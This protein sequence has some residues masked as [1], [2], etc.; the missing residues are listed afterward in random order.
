MISMAKFVFR[1]NRS[2]RLLAGALALALSF[3]WVLPLQ[4][5]DALEVVKK[6]DAHYYYP[7]RQGVK[8]LSVLIDW[9]QMD[10]ASLDQRY[11]TNP[12]ARFVW[13]RG[14]AGKFSIVDVEKLSQ[15]SRIRTLE[16]FGNYEEVVVPKTLA[17][18]LERYELNVAD[19]SGGRI[20]LNAVSMNAK[21]KIQSYRFLVDAKNWRI[22][23]VRMRTSGQ[24]REISS[25]FRYAKK[26]GKWLLSHSQ[27]RFSVQGKNY[28]EDSEYDYKQEN[29]LWLLRRL[30]QDL[31]QKTEVVRSYIL[32]A[33]DFKIN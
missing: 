7:Q 9:R 31:K 24:P 11:L 27:A 23:K 6:L 4:A 26:N 1:S 32:R 33:G 17:E 12:Q 28:I 25:Q 14:G 10:V 29:G 13:A 2:R 15:D 3:V 21:E 18:Q 22:E 8:K 20:L 30:Q 16:F 19:Q 5:Q